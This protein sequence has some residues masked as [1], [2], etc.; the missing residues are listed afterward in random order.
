MPV[1]YYRK[2]RKVNINGQTVYKYVADLKQGEAIKIEKIAE[3]VEKSSGLTKGDLINGIYQMLS[4]AEDYLIEGHK[5]DFSPLGSLTPSINAV[6][7]DTPDEVTAKTIKRF[8]PI[9]KASVSLKKKFKEAE[10]RLGD[11]K[12]REVKKRKKDEGI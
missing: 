10:F 5:V 6:A 4:I 12:V 2:R 1:R 11:N 9:F 7:C 8:Y 3:I